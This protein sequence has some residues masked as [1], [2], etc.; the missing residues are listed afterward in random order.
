MA[1]LKSYESA[2]CMSQMRE[3]IRDKS[4][5]LS[6]GALASPSS[7]EPIPGSGR[8]GNQTWQGQAIETVVQPAQTLSTTQAHGHL[9]EATGDVCGSAA[10]ALNET[11][12]PLTGAVSPSA[13]RENSVSVHASAG[14]P[15]A[16]AD[17]TFVFPADT[18]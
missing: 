3:A 16:H 11:W 2:A 13:A 8:S 12:K 1:T 7:P 9:N 18:H 17:S 14:E 5:D 10:P 4:N 15:G 6:T